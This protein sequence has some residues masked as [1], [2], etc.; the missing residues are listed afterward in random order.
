LGCGGFGRWA[1]QSRGPGCCLIQRAHVDVSFD[2]EWSIEVGCVQ[3]CDQDQIVQREHT[4]HC[5]K[6]MFHRNDPVQKHRMD[7]IQCIHVVVPNVL[8]TFHLALVS[9]YIH[10]NHM[11]C[12]YHDSRVGVGVG[13][14]FFGV[15]ISPNLLTLEHLTALRTRAMRYGWIVFMKYQL[16]ANQTV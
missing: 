16:V 4:C 15:A 13:P 7:G 11:H 9:S 2:G 1:S 14:I 10:K 8:C 5:Q 6:R 3:P 12:I